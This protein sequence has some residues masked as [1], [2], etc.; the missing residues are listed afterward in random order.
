MAR[1]CPQTTPG[2]FVCCRLGQHTLPLALGILL[3]VCKKQVPSLSR[4]VLLQC[5]VDLVG[6]E[7]AAD[8]NE[9]GVM[10]LGSKA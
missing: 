2:V 1:Q 4:C 6:A 7:H 8:D 10:V 3:I 5:S 9:G